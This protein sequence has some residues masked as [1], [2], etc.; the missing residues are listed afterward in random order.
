MI[1][2]LVFFVFIALAGCGVKSSSSGSGKVSLVK[3]FS[4]PDGSTMYFMGPLFFASKSDH[5]D[6]EIDY[7]YIPLADD[8]VTANFTILS[9]SA[10]DFAFNGMEFSGDEPIASTTS[11]KLFFKEKRGKSFAFRYSV[12]IEAKAWRT[13]MKSASPTIRV[14][15]MVF[16]P[17]KKHRKHMQAVRDQVLFPTE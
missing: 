1:R 6:M 14:N 7:T 12:R 13:F 4:R 2:Y 3:V 11:A 17:G 8:S 5:A 16:T 15:S 10:S 9:R